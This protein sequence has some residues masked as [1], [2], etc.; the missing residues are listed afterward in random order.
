MYHNSLS[1]CFNSTYR[2]SSILPIMFSAYERSR[3][4]VT[5]SLIRSWSSLDS[6]TSATVRPILRFCLHV[7]IQPGDWKLS[8]SLRKW[9]NNTKQINNLPHPKQL[10]ILHRHIYLKS[11]RFFWMSGSRESCSIWTSCLFISSGISSVRRRST[12]N[13]RNNQSRVRFKARRAVMEHH[14]CL[15]YTYVVPVLKDFCHHNLEGFTKQ[16]THLE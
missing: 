16:R 13:N 9:L 14:G 1:V 4:K 5:R 8:M 11:S 6:S 7:Q 2:M 12:S 10:I 15:I 3:S